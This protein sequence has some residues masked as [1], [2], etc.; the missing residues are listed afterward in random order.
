MQLITITW[1]FLYICPKLYFVNDNL[2]TLCQLASV[3]CLLI[4]I[5]IGPSADGEIFYRHPMFCSV[6]TLYFLE[7]LYHNIGKIKSIPADFHYSTPPSRSLGLV[8]WPTCI[9]QFCEIR[10]VMGFSPFY[11]LFFSY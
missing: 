4:S 7:R 11:S 2:Y 1:V 6:S 3:A 5:H 8:D 10:Y 9:I